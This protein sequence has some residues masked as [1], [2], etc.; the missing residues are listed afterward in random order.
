M[1]RI[2]KQ[3]IK[4]P[5]GVK[6]TLSENILT[7]TKGN[8]SESYNIPHC[9]QTKI[10]ND[11]LLFSPIKKNKQTSTLWGTTQRN[12]HNLIHGLVNDFKINLKLS[13]VGYKAAL[14]GKQLV[15]QLG[16]SHAVTYDI[17][18]G[19]TVSCTDPTTLVISGRSKKQVGDTA[20]LLRTYRK[21]EPYKGKGII[22][23]GE[24]VYR[25]EGKKK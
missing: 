22:R 18:E 9:I 12:V 17:P 10:E 23:V 14:K 20:A 8:I 2:G 24:F 6:V 11:S 7:A 15:L 1:S 4:I 25:K 3:I 5:E 21:P 13:G 16:F 19:I